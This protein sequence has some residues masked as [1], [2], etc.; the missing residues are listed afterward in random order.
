VPNSARRK[1][2][3][4]SWPPSTSTFQRPWLRSVD[5]RARQVMGTQSKA[6]LPGRA[7]CEGRRALPGS[8]RQVGSVVR[9]GHEARTATRI[10]P[11]VRSHTC[12]VPA[13]ANAYQI[14]DHCRGRLG[15]SAQGERPRAVRLSRRR[16]ED[17]L[18]MNSEPPWVDSLH[19]LAHGLHLTAYVRS[20]RREADSRRS[21]GTI[22]LSRSKDDQPIGS[23]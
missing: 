10:G 18:K 12:G 7:P 15:R 6:L 21:P 3:C 14:Q 5:Q 1:P 13:S 11:R 16:F 2:E 20:P 23:L 9:P 19:L 4:H 17:R 22:P 8:A